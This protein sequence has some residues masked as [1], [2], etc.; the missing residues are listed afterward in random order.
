MQVASA[1][2]HPTASN[3]S[4]RRDARL[5]TRAVIANVE[6]IALCCGQDVSRQCQ[7]TPISEDQELEPGMLGLAGH[8][9]RQPARLWR[10][11]RAPAN[12]W[13]TSEVLAK[14]QSAVAI[15]PTHTRSSFRLSRLSQPVTCL[16]LQLHFHRA[17]APFANAR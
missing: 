2:M 13:R 16:S 14:V 15:R 1:G 5:W 9:T 3:R 12:M 6:P 10:S 17:L 7:L 4:S 8:G 11:R